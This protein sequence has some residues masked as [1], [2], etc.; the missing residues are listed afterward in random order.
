[1]L[2]LN[3]VPVVKCILFK[4]ELT[5]PTKHPPAPLVHREILVTRGQRLVLR[6]VQMATIHLVVKKYALY[7]QP[8]PT[9]KTKRNI[10]FFES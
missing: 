5:A 9:A 4:Q 10:H 3:K 8:E 7:V 2:C 1:M 6:L